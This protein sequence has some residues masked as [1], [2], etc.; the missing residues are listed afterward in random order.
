MDC[1]HMP[2]K[3]R[4]KA[5][6]LITSYGDTLD[7]LF[8][9]IYPLYWDFIILSYVTPYGDTLGTPLPM[10]AEI[11]SLA[12]HHLSPW[13]HLTH[14]STPCGNAARNL[15]TQ[16]SISFHPKVSQGDDL[17]S[18]NNIC[19]K[20]NWVAARSRKCGVLSWFW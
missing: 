6:L 15:T 16:Y 17:R 20:P 3:L 14:H 1:P 8:P 10:W 11:S 9:H 2:S 7:I 13:V 4:L 19:S 12:T 5:Y 18:T